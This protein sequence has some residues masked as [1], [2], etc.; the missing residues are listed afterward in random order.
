MNLCASAAAGLVSALRL[1]G[2]SPLQFDPP[3]P[4]QQAAIDDLKKSFAEDAREDG[5]TAKAFC[6]SPSFKNLQC[7]FASDAEVAATIK[8][9]CPL[10][11][12]LYR[13]LPNKT[14]LPAEV[15]GCPGGCSYN[16]L[17]T[18]L[19]SLACK[20]PVVVRSVFKMLAES[21]LTQE[22]A[23]S[24]GFDGTDCTNSRIELMDDEPTTKGGNASDVIRCELELPS[25]GGSEAER[26]L[27]GKESKCWVCA[28]CRD[29]GG[30][31]SEVGKWYSDSF[32]TKA[33]GCDIDPQ[34]GYVYHRAGININPQTKILLAKFEVCNNPG[35][36]DPAAEK[37]KQQAAK[38]CVKGKCTA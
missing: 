36:F 25:G 14:Q 28:L 37:A 11:G 9:Q 35:C 31:P 21:K 18:E 23:R 7:G 5:R 27:K 6:A 26:A 34:K 19:F 10:C 20:G 32:T 13:G 24:Y 1:A 12:T 4:A 17:G 30:C 3:T 29:G 8:K 2:R 22:Q 16:Q 38:A 33:T 15:V